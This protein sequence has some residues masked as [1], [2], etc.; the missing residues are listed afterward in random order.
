MRFAIILFLISFFPAVANAERSVSFAEAADSGGALIAAVSDAENLGDLAGILGDEAVEDVRRAIAAKGFAADVGATL[1]VVS[2]AEEF[3][4]IH[5]VG[6]GADDM[7][8]RDWENFGGRAGALA[9]TTKAE[10]VSVAAFGASNEALQRVGVG[11]MLGAYSFDKYKSDHEPVT[12]ALNIISTDSGAAT[13]A[14]DARGRH[15]ANAVI[16]V[17]NMQSEPANIIYPE[18]FVRRARAELRGVSNI[19]VQ[20]LDVGDMER[21]G[22][23]AILGVG[24]G[25]DRPPRMMIV[26]YQGGGDEAPIVY[27]GKGITFDTGGISLKRNAGM[28]AMKADMTGAA[29][30]MGAV[31]SLAKSHAPVNIVAIA[32]LAENMPGSG[33]QRPGDVVKTMSGKT[34]EIMSTDAEGRLVLSDAVWYAQERYNPRLLV[35]VATLTGSVGRALGDEYAGLFSWDDGIAARV[36]AAGEASGDDVWR[37]PLHK[38]YNEQIKSVI[39]DFKNGST[40]APGASTGAAFIGAFVKEETPWAHLDIAGMDWREEATATMP[41]GASGFSVRLLDHLARDETE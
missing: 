11:A 24:Q 34:I 17:R 8:L 41:L 20:V 31:Q 38:K 4:E 27:A 32:A 35:D 2:G 26:R 13:A 9:K 15:L 1:S 23:G 10:I 19:S 14:F 28:W 5:L 12:G 39:A 6:I 22:M 40:G 30:V 33:A 29:A 25:S 21:L 7:R 36:K 16:W 3:G 18:E 37:L